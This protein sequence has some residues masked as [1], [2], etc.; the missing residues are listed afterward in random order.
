MKQKMN[1]FEL[2]CRSLNRLRRVLSNKP[3]VNKLIEG[4]L[5][6]V[7][8]ANGKF[9]FVF[10]EKG[11]PAIIAMGIKLLA[12]MVCSPNKS[13]IGFVELKRVALARQLPAELVLTTAIGLLF[14]EPA[15]KVK[16]KYEATID[17]LGNIK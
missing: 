4:K 10:G 5:Q 12:K 6:S 16:G 9:S 14:C 3:E 15:I 17:S 11:D 2:A 13:R 8:L 1:D 7:V